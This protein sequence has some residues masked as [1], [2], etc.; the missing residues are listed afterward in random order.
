MQSFPYSVNSG[1]SSR[2]HGS[3]DLPQGYAGVAAEAFGTGGTQSQLPPLLPQ[4]NHKRQ[5][6][7]KAKRSEAAAS[8]AA[9][10]AAAAN[11]S[12]NDE[13]EGSGKRRR[14]Q[15][16]CDSEC[17]RVASREMVCKEG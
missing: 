2:Q 6:S 16:A 12:G 1:E 7:I 14:V 5:A 3:M 11:D 17:R 15:R 4:Q 8:K 10:D 9:A 13:D